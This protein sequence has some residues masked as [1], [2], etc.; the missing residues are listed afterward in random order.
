M[1]T[2][3]KGTAMN[4]INTLQIDNKQEPIVVSNP[5]TFIPAMKELV[6]HVNFN[7]D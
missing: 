5:E 4:T 7:N 1:A 6:G 3:Q 2:D